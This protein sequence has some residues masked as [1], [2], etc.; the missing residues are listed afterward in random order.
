[1]EIL[2]GQCSFN[3]HLEKL[4]ISTDILCKFYAKSDENFIHIL[5]KC[6]A[7]VALICQ[8]YYKHIALVYQESS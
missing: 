1:M 2:A 3:Y 7:L 8:I 6:L 5:G 4:S